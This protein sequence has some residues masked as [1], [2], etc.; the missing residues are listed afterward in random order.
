MTSKTEGKEKRGDQIDA[1]IKEK[2]KP[3]D[4]DE[5]FASKEQ[6]IIE[7]KA[8]YVRET[9]EKL[10]TL[11]ADRQLRTEYSNKLF[12]LICAWLGGMG[13]LYILTGLGAACGWFKIPAAA[14]T[15]LL[16]G[17][18]I[19]VVGLFAVVARYLFSEKRIA[20]SDL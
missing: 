7:D 11:K 15:T 13:A 17:T 6:S 12:R 14:I 3:K 20:A 2:G 19:G 10:L 8:S 4:T 9:N 1:K 18:T 16:G 5:V